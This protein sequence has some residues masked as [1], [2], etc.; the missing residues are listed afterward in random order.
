MSNK[1][2]GLRQNIDAQLDRLIE[3]LSDLDQAKS[4]MDT[5]EFNEAR[6]D[7][8]EQLK[9]FSKSLE[10]MKSGEGG[11][12]LIDDLQ[13]IQNVRLRSTKQIFF[14]FFL[15]TFPGD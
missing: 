15:S 13:R 6:E 2:D 4:E 8:L 9:D 11:L 5:D 10:K 3:Q 12:S 7:T 14:E 1:S